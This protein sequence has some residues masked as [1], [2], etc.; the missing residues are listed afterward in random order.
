MFKFKPISNLPVR[1]VQLPFILNKNIPVLPGEIQAKQISILPQRHVD[2]NHALN[3]GESTKTIISVMGHLNGLADYLRGSILLAQYAKHFNIHFKMNVSKHLI[4][5]CLLVESEPISPK[6]IHTLMICHKY[7]HLNYYVSRLIQDFVT[8]EETELY[9]YSNLFYDRELLTDDIKHYINSFFTFKP[10]YYEDM[11]RL[12]KFSKYQVLHIRCSD[13]HFNGMFQDNNLL[14]EI[15]KL[16]LPPPIIVMSNNHYLKQQLHRLFGFTM[17]D[18]PAYH[19]ATSQECQN[20]YSTIV[21]YMILSQSSYTNCFSYYG[22]GSG[23]SEQCSI[24]NNVPYHC[25]YVPNIIDPPNPKLLFSHYECLLGPS[26]TFEVRDIQASIKFIACGTPNMNSIQSLKNHNI[27]PYE[28]IESSKWESIYTHLCTHEFVCVTTSDTLYE[29]HQIFQYLL[30]QIQ[31]Y[32]ILLPR[33]SIETPNVHF[34]FMFISSNEATKKL[35]SGKEDYVSILTTLHMKKLPLYLFPTWEHYT[36]YTTTPYMI[37]GGWAQSLIFYI[38][39][40]DR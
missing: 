19:I 23:F 16:Q 21:D 39:V 13:T 2:F 17:V 27:E 9:V 15:I 24:L 37:Q 11:H 14:T 7:T 3:S 26:A 36:T 34:N 32:D 28:C 22:H 4:N 8:N 12:F 30:T 31:D 6:K 5:Q 10:S 33:E 35:F 40:S 18:T 25:M 29:N 38:F 20:L 1:P